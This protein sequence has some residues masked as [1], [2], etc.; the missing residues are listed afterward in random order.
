MMTH[1]AAEKHIAAVGR[2]TAKRAEFEKTVAAAAA[3]AASKA[4]SV[5]SSTSSSV[6]AAAAAAASAVAAT[7]PVRKLLTTL[8][9]LLDRNVRIHGANKAV[10]VSPLSVTVGT[11]LF[12]QELRDEFRLDFV[13]TMAVSRTPLSRAPYFVP[14]LRKYVPHVGGCIPEKADLG[15]TDLSKLR[16]EH[17]DMLNARI[18]GQPCTVQI[19]ETPDREN[20][21]VINQVVGVLG[22]YYL[23]KT[24]FAKEVN[25]T[26][27]QQQVLTMTRER[28]IP[29]D[30]LDAF[31][32]DSAAYNGV[33]Y[34][35]LAST[36]P[37]L[38][39]V[40]C[41]AHLWHL[42]AQSV[43]LHAAFKFIFQLARSLACVACSDNLFAR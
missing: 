21:S 17:E 29:F 26:V 3:S 12:P 30:M 8:E 27:I 11:H 5:P 34:S 4:A 1:M 24:A 32:V 9:T 31:V 10:D 16:T 20:R 15:T 38:I 33:A 43:Y 42:V 22:T 28:S 23:V 2:A 37:N 40:R 39:H 41:W 35:H 14:F 18:R 6:A 25:N 19:D 36:F 13:R 7:Q